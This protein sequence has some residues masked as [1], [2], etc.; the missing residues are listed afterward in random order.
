MPQH[1]L[2][3][4]R[5]QRLC[6]TVRLTTVRGDVTKVGRYGAAQAVSVEV[7][8]KRVP[9][10]IRRLVAGAA[11][12]TSA[13]SAHTSAPAAHASPPSS[14]GIATVGVVVI[15]VKGNA[16]LLACLPVAGAHIE[17]LLP[18]VTQVKTAFQRDTE[19]QHWNDY[20]D[21]EEAHTSVSGGADAH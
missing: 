11:A 10:I 3:T 17:V 20:L 5:H 7:D 2:A 6:P 12:T 15:G 18:P 19:E 16:W 4:R 21:K 1:R 14:R 8:T 13:A 9:R